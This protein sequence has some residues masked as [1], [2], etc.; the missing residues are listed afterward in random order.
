MRAGPI[1]RP[2]PQRLAELPRRGALGLALSACLGVAACGSSGDAQ[3]SEAGAKR[4]G[5]AAPSP[6]AAPPEHS[7]P[8]SA[9][10]A[11]APSELDEAPTALA[12]APAE[13]PAP[14]P[15][16]P[17]YPLGVAGIDSA[18]TTASLPGHLRF[19]LRSGEAPLNA[20]L[21][22]LSLRRSAGAPLPLE[23]LA[24]QLWARDA[25]E[26]VELDADEAITLEP[27]REAELLLYLDSWQG[28]PRAERYV[29]DATFSVDG[30]REQIT[31]NIERARR[32]PR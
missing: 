7:P 21:E 5:K 15:S 20:S 2:A 24:L 27:Q 4:G 26:P 12:E 28:D 9:E 3:P 19:S 32:E 29:F 11:G 23:P 30:V 6:S 16:G 18:V 22:D 31:V 10:A 8:P 17:V 25:D 13:Q 1:S 14:I